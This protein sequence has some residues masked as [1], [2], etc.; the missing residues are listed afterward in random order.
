MPRLCFHQL[1]VTEKFISLQCTTVHL[2]LL[3]YIL[4]LLLLKVIQFFLY[5][6]SLLLCTEGGFQLCSLADFIKILLITTNFLSLTLAG[7]YRIITGYLLC[8][9]TVSLMLSF[10]I[11]LW[12]GCQLLFTCL[13]LNV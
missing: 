10:P 3:H 1:Q 12:T 13:F 6:S 2:V 4:F 9:I 5:V 7:P 11:S 8:E